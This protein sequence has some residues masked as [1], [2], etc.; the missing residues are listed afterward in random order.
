MNDP[1]TV[2]VTAAGGGGVGEQILKALSH[3]TLALYVIAADCDEPVPTFSANTTAILPPASAADYM[4]ELLSLCKRKRIRVVFPGSEA[5]LRVLSAHAGQLQEH[6]IFFPAA[7]S[8][9]IELCLDKCALFA[10]LAAK[11]FA[12]PA[13]NRIRS[14]DELL[15][16]LNSQPVWP[17][18]C[19]PDGKSSGSGGSVDV[20]IAQNR[21]EGDFFGTW[22][23]REHGA[24]MMQEYVGTPDQEFTLGV[25][26][27]MA[28]ELI[29]S[30]ALKRDLRP[31]LSRRLR[32]RNR[33][34]RKE[35]GEWLAISSGVSQGCFDE[36]PEPRRQAEAMAHAL[37]A[38]GPL[39][40]QG[41]LV[42]DHF[43]LF[44]INPRFS[45]TTS[46][47]AMAGFNE[48]ELLI[49]RHVLHEDPA[50]TSYQHCTIRRGL[51]ERPLFAI[52]AAR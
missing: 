40:F 1:L 32:V 25:L 2:L 4:S 7:P 20:F 36:W 5:E 30:I 21:E 19:K 23:L 46:L 48:P 44:E 31:A 15:V 50:P 51:E 18:V 41:R 28:G 10:E 3:S 27:D 47:R 39:N 52:P 42:G 14:R 16:L 12:V 33:T 9:L 26:H 49:R 38:C 43:F 22:L 45:G 8:S 34:D 35:L 6:G 29:G 24:F 13:F 11:G 37:G 17:M